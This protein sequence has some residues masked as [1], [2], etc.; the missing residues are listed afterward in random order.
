MWGQIELFRR[1]K[2]GEQR[3]KKGE[4]EKLAAWG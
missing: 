1:K 4:E 2:G 3:G